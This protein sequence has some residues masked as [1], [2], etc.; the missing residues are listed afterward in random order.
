MA[1]SSDPRAAN[2]NAALFRDA[3]KFAMKMGAPEDENLRATFIWRTEKTFSKTDSSGKPWLK[4]APVLLNNT[5]DPVLIDVAVTFIPRTTLSGG[6]PVGQ[7][8]TPRAI[9]TVLDD[10]YALISD[11]NGVVLPS[12]VKL[13]ENTYT[14]DYVEPPVGLFSVTV[15]QIHCSARDES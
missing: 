2:F 1:S 3:V 14:I 15:Y 11:E 6:T 10:D 12:E 13:G 9:I 7:F 4:N 8:D 5:P